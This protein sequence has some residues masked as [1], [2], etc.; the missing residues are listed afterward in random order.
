MLQL[1][2]TD[3]PKAGR[4]RFSKALPAV[5]D[6]NITASLPPPPQYLPSLPPPSP[7]K[8]SAASHSQ[9]P[10]PSLPASKPLPS[11]VFP[12]GPA[13]SMS[14]PRKPIG[15]IQVSAPPPPLPPQP[16]SPT[17]SIESILSAYS[18]SSGES[19]VRMSDGSASMRESDATM[20]PPYVAPVLPPTVAKGSLPKPAQHLQ[21]KAVGGGGPPPSPPTK[22]ERFQPLVAS[23]SSQ[24][25]NLEMDT[26]QPPQPQLW[27]RRSRSSSRGL[28]DL[29]LDHSHGSTA[30]TQATIQNTQ[31]QSSS[32]TLRAPLGS[33]QVSGNVKGLPGRNVRPVGSESDVKLGEKP[34]P[35]VQPEYAPT[36]PAMNRPPTP[37]YQ[38]ED[39]KTPVINT[40]VSPVSPASSPE[41]AKYRGTAPQVSPQTDIAQA[42]QPPAAS[43]SISEKPGPQKVFPGTSPDLHVARSVPNLRNKTP[44]PVNEPLP[45]DNSFGESVMG[46]GHVTNEIPTDRFR[47]S[48]DSMSSR[49]RSSSARPG[50]R[51]P[52]EQS[53]P[54]APES[55]PRLVHSESQGY[56]YRGRDGTLYPEMKDVREPDARAFNFPKQTQ[57]LLPDD[58]INRAAPLKASHYD[59]F[60]G[61]RSM[62]RRSNR[63]CPVTC[64][65]CERSDAE[66]RWTC[67]FC[68]VR[69]CEACFRTFNDNQRDL[70]RLADALAHEPEDTV[71]S[72]SSWQRSGSA[73]GIIS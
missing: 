66:D 62:N 33:S 47:H 28:T 72:L 11:L 73:L 20:S 60:Q 4:S 46:R 56:L 43:R 27:R 23:K 42:S 19:L 17:D 70:H 65:T 54:L 2:T 55:D 21:R 9:S 50:Q 31:S 57:Q 13:P 36:R 41:P 34:L 63:H 49:A 10:L 22:D 40:Y 15:K 32:E 37:E 1:P 71:V 67:S 30:S 52:M 68:Y 38:K 48:G 5:P 64:Q 24:P 6:L 16:P 25:S 26:P 3:A 7:S 12:S 14:I 8:A 59:C 18:R 53:R 61:H 35:S 69:M 45:R 44:S 51:R 29:K 58:T 39:V